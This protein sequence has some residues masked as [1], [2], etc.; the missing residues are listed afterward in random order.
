MNQDLADGTLRYAAECS[1]Q[2]ARRL[3]G[4]PDGHRAGYLHGHGFRVRVVGSLADGRGPFQ[5]AEPDALSA[6]LA[7]L[8]APLDYRY[9]NDIL[10]E[11]DDLRLADWVRQRLACAGAQ[12]AVAS[13]PARGGMIGVDGATTV[14][15]R[16]Q[17]E[18]A[19]RL[20]NV[21][22]GHQCGRMHGH[23]F[24][25]LLHAGVDRWASATLMQDRL[26]ACW[27]PFLDRLQHACLNDLPGLENPTSEALAAWLWQGLAPELPELALVTVHETASA[28][29]HYDGL[30]YRIWKEQ[31]FESALR[32]SAAPAGDHRARLHGHSYLLRL[33]ISAPLDPVMCW[34]LDYGDV[35]E[36]FRPIYAALDHHCR[37]DLTGLDEPSL[38]GLLRWMRSCLSGRLPQLYRIDLYQTPEAGALLSWGRDRHFLPI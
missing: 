12:V 37:N 30:H 34:T 6:Y 16:F 1:L 14:W 8:L 7:H 31:R 26:D 2:A 33:H 11:P 19:H 35:K 24:V 32:L 17:F 21:P 25:V 27:Q 5:G 13:E 9:L 22:P 28:G 15:R 29:C 10:D 3:S 18:A 38:A 36:L 20:P 23:G 4:L